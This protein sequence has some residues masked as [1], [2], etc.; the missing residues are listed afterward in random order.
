MFLNVFG[1]F[2]FV[3][4]ILALLN[5]LV[6]EEVRQLNNVVNVVTVF[7]VVRFVYHTNVVENIVFP[8]HKLKQNNANW[9][10]IRLVGLVCMMKY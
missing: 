7:D 8:R 6:S 1:Q 5:N 3:A 10:N 4:Q 9:P 2:Q